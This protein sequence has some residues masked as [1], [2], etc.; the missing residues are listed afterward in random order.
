MTESMFMPCDEWS[1]KL[2]ASSEDLSVSDRAAFEAHLKGCPACLL[3][4]IDNQ[5]ISRLIR[6]LPS[7]DFGIGLSPRL[8]QL[9]Q[10]ADE[11]EVR[12]LQNSL[13]MIDIQQQALEVVSEALQRPG[14]EE[15]SETPPASNSS[16]LEPPKRPQRIPL[17]QTSPWAGY[18]GNVRDRIF[19][20]R[21]CGQVFT[22]SAG[23]QALYARRNLA[24]DPPRCPSCRAA[25]CGGGNQPSSRPRTNTGDYYETI[26]ADCGQATSIPFIPRED[27]PVY[28]SDCFQMRRAPR[29]HRQSRD[30]RSNS[31]RNQ[32]KD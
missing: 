10:Q 7:P 1:E 12:A 5:M 32:D 8:T 26:C 28:C 2:N 21:D 18:D 6:A 14:K 25:R 27:Q 13:P 22:F 19:T 9:L 16:L 30:T 11:C 15:V 29:T 20:C 31:P 3:V 23:E 24:G 4:R 17:A